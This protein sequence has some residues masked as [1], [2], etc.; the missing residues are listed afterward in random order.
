MHAVVVNVAIDS[1]VGDDV[2][3]FLRSKVVPLMSQLPG[4]VSGTWTKGASEGRSM[5]VFESEDAAAGAVGVIQNA[6]RPDGVTVVSAD[7]F[8]VVAQA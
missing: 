1:S 2:V 6:Q 8:E 7:V 3:E 4:F 5:L